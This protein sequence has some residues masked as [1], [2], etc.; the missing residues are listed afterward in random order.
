MERIKDKIKAIIFDMDGTIVKTEHIWHA[1]TQRVL[2]ERGFTNFSADQEKFLESL[3]GIGLIKAA[4]AI[5]KE[6]KLLDSIATLTG[7]TKQIAHSLLNDGLE[8][9]DGFESFHKK[10]QESF[11]PT[12][13]ASN[14]DHSSLV[15][16]NEK[17][18]LHKFFGKNIFSIEIVGNIPKP[19][20]D[21]FLHAAKQLKV[22]PREC[23][24]FE[25]S[26][27][28]FQAA[29]AA[30]MRCIAIKNKINHKNLGLVDH[31]ISSYH[32]AEEALL[33]LPFSG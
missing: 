8:F 28:G 27:F 15:L 2:E 12:S 30:G 20:P 9:I 31:A 10:L 7:Q 4:E 14:A 5:K 32:E 21:I 11:I 19:S 22:D 17:M 6:F 24:V 29:Q 25:D 3:S 33:T 1:A 16:F 18:K 23:V 13:V 26:L